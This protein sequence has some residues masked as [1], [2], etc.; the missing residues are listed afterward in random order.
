MAAP[1]LASANAD[2]DYL[3]T[4]VARALQ[5]TA[6]Q[7]ALAVKHYRAVGIW[8]AAPDSPLFRFRP[9]IYPQGSMALETTVRPRF[10]DEYDLDL[11]CQL[12]TTGLSA[13]EVY[14]LVHNRLAA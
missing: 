12:L 14:H 1:Y 13:M 10:R 7:Y 2:L 11:V 8:L 5:L 4:E 3:L 6:E 9:S